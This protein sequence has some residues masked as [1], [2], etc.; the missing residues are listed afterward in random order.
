MTVSIAIKQ[1]W[2]RQ[3]VE[4]TPRQPALNGPLPLHEELL[5]MARQRIQTLS[6]VLKDKSECKEVK[7]VKSSKVKIIKVK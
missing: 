6:E 1:N 5:W 2:R 4:F 3:C 7:D